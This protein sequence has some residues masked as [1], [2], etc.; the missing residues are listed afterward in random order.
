MTERAWTKH[1]VFAIVVA[2]LIAGTAGAQ[3]WVPVVGN[4][5]I[6]HVSNN[7]HGSGAGL[8]VHDGYAYST[9]QSG[10]LNIIDISD[11][12]DPTTVATVDEYARD[13]AILEVEDRTLAATGADPSSHTDIIDVTDPEDPHVIERVNLG[14]GSH[15]IAAL[16]GEA[17][18]YN[19]RSSSWNTGIDIVDV[20]DPDD[21]EVATVW[22]DG[23]LTCHDIEAYPEADRAYCAGL[24]ETYVMDISDPLDPVVLSTVDNDEISL[25]HWALATPDHDT[26]II[27]D[28]D[29]SPSDGCGSGTH[30]PVA[31]LG[32]TDGAIWFFDI[33]N[34]EEPVEL[35]SVTPPQAGTGAW[36]TSHFGDIVD[37]LPLLVVG[38]YT[39]GVVVIDWGEPGLPTVVEQWNPGDA[40]VW[41]VQHED[42][43]LYT[44]DLNRGL[45]VLELDI[46]L[47]PQTG[48]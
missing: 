7:P 14:G 38:W 24:G 31:S 34:P 13:V 18:F 35:S 25:H 2:M 33:T 43:Y 20:S 46:T 27:G 39:A 3:T 45:D 4:A 29:F 12:Q 15:N 44:G 30:T 10:G 48:L 19:S 47:G 22:D 16:E 40:D 17:L 28:E 36:C 21:P 23:G 26:L 32:G 37:G 6:E 41:D 11:P 1:A 42:G 8:L 5:Q 9:A